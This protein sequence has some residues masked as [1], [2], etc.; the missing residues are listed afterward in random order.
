[1]KKATEIAQFF[2]RIALGV[3]FVA[4]CMDRFGL[5]GAPGSAGVSWGDWNHFSIYAHKM[6]F[7]LPSAWAEIFA[8][9][10]SVAELLLG[11]L[12]I[13][14]LFTR[15]TSIGSGLLLIGFGISMAVAWGIHAPL[16]YSVFTAAGAAFL[17]AAIPGYRW[18]VDAVLKNKTKRNSSRVLQ[19][20]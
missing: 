10:A 8:V 13:I 2:L 4:A 15:W 6:M 18:S 19:L 12:L 7:F 1:M 20:V 9:L 11:I 3:S 14:G 5:S 17:L 16:S